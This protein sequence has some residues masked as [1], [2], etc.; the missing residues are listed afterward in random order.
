MRVI[1]LL[2]AILAATGAPGFAQPAPHRLLIHVDS[3]QAEVMREALHNAANVIDMMRKE[4][5]KV[6]I[7]I[8]T[9]G[10]GTAMFIAELSPVQN[11]V[12]RIHA[13]YPDV[14][15]SVCGIS[16]AHTEAAMK[17]KLTVMR[18]ARVVPSGALRI[19]ELEEQHWAY[20]KP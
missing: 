18:E 10:P 17:K 6:A 9:N 1:I 3:P 15:M 19:M 14:V 11:E 8:V 7:E 4:G 20:L 12:R 5:G 16:L 13:L 2:F